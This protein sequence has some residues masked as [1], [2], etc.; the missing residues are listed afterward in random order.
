[1]QKSKTNYNSTELQNEERR[2]E[3]PVGLFQGLV[4][5]WTLS[6]APANFAYAWKSVTAKQLDEYTSFYFIFTYKNF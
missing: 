1:M 3:L 5:L 2:L 4:I 6:G